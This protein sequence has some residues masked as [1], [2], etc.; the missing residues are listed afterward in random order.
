MAKFSHAVDTGRDGLFIAR[1]AACDDIIYRHEQHDI[2]DQE[3]INASRRHARAPLH[4]E[5]SERRQMGGSTYEFIGASLRRLR[6][7]LALRYFTIFDDERRLFI[8]FQM[9]LR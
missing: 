2:F 6:S 3:F 1:Y 7:R 8:A 5:E 9:P 4:I